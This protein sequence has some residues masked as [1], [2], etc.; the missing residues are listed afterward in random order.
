M[1]KAFRCFGL[2][3]KRSIVSAIKIAVPNSDKYHADT[4]FSISARSKVIGKSEY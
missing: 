1:N 3:I 4:N 2:S